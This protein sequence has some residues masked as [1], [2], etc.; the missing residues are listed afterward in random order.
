MRLRHLHPFFSERSVAANALGL[1][2]RDRRCNSCRS[3]QFFQVRGPVSRAPARDAGEVGAIPT[4]LTSL[5]L[6]SYGSAS[7]VTEDKLAESP[8]CRAGKSGGSTRRSR[9][10]HLIGAGAQQRDRAAEDGVQRA[11]C[12]E[13]EP[14]RSRAPFFGRVVQQLRPLSYTE[15]ITVQIRACPP[16]SGSSIVE[17]PSVNRQDAGASPAPTAI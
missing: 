6:S 1:G 3:D 14:I 11:E 5:R 15:E 17:R 8:A 10:F 13:H 12:D 7:R 2:P 4:H 9:H 16:L